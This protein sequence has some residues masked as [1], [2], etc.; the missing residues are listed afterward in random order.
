LEKLAR[1]ALDEMVQLVGVLT[2]D[3][4]VLECNRSALVA[5]GLGREDVIGKPL[6]ETAW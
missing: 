5:A 3:G 6:W 4:I 1:I 2:P